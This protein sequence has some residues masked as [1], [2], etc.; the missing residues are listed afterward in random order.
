MVPGQVHSIADKTVV[1]V[2]FLISNI[3]VVAVRVVI[4]IGI[5]KV[6]IIPTIIG[7]AGTQHITMTQVTGESRG[8]YGQDPLGRG[9]RLVADGDQLD[10]VVGTRT[11]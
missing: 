7:W 1:V 11:G 5:T 3:I 4:I 8:R 9:S 2:R 6:I 10:I